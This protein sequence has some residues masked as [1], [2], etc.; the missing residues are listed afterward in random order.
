MDYLRFR[1]SLAIARDRSTSDTD[2]LVALRLGMREWS[3]R[4][5]LGGL[6]GE[7]AAQARSRLRIEQKHAAVELVRVTQALGDLEAAIAE[8]EQ[9][10]MLWPTDEQMIKLLLDC[11]TA[12]HNVRAAEEWLDDWYAEHPD[13]S[14]RLRAHIRGLATPGGS[15]RVLGRA[16]HLVVPREVPS[17]G[18]PLRGRES[19]LDELVSAI[20]APARNCGVFVITGMP[21]VGKTALVRRLANLVKHLF[22]DG[23][24]YLDLQGFTSAD[25][26]PLAPEVALSHCLTAFGLKDTPSS[27]A[28][29]AALFR[30]ILAERSVL[31]VLDNARNSEQIRS[32]IGSNKRCATLIT[33]R[34][35]L[36]DLTAD[37]EVQVTEIRPLADTAAKSLL[38]DAMHGEVDDEADLL[39][40]Q[41][42]Q[43]CSGVPLALQLVAARLRNQPAAAL[44]DFVSSMGENRATVLD[45]RNRLAVWPA[46]RCSY[47]TLSPDAGRLLW[48][49][50]LYPGADIS[51]GALSD[52]A[53]AG[54]VKDVH[55]A[56]GELVTGNLLECSEGAYRM[57]D[58]IRAYATELAE[59]DD[60]GLGEQTRQRVFE[61]LLQNVWA[62][63][64]VLAPDRGLPIHPCAAVEPIRPKDENAAMAWLEQAYGP[65][66]AAIRLA[67][68]AGQHRTMWL[69]SLA[70]MTYQWRLNLHAAAEENLSAA[71][72][73]THDI[74]TPEE[75]STL[76][77][78]L[79]GCCFNQGRLAEGVAHL[80]RAIALVEGSNAAT[81]RLSLGRSLHTLGLVRK[82]EK[83]EAEAMEHL[84][85]ALDVLRPLDD[86]PTIGAA[87][88][89]LAEIHCDRG[90]YDRALDLCFKAQAAFQLSRDR[91]GR[92]SVQ[93]TFG[94][95]HQAR[96]EP[97]P[98]QA[99]FRQA[100]SIYKELRYD[101]NIGRTLCA[102]ADLHL[103]SGAVQQAREALEEAHTAFT[104]AG[105]G[106]AESVRHRLDTM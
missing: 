49:L 53:R 1:H 81:D 71:L 88:E 104:R 52:I 25:T 57:H 85:H 83:H 102:L 61:H 8:A 34:N 24:L 36:S 98:A 44:G 23:A 59:A 4:E 94:T 62:C 15:Q 3:P 77:R 12:A 46:Y 6:T 58:L 29:K 14:Q 38:L 76:H 48:Q 67:R 87:L 55:R 60:T 105:D 45:D 54:A 93:R 89:C 26:A 95:I 80:H 69:L 72:H 56:A 106:F 79:A 21:G 11:I 9:F 2:R 19:T 99:A 40:D 17:A 82:T 16:A 50:T 43:W 10:L 31:V 103:E 86:H 75:R 101:R 13:G 37:E 92:A 20:A 5:I 70:V 97:G 51:W 22:P 68:E 7:W 66:T 100:L 32:L 27:L 96:S 41:L 47:Q 28:D 91:N 65:V 42:V 64:Q 33:S 39:L 78:M 74:T 18:P 63:D 35:R 73:L 90:E 84:H 30:S